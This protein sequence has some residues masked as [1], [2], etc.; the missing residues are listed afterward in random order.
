MC[1]IF[2]GAGI[3]RVKEEIHILVIEDV[4]TDVVMIN[5]ELRRGRM[6]FRSKRVETRDA[7]L[8]ELEQN[9]PDVIL[10]DHGLPSFDGFTALA[11]AKDKCPDVPF[12]F[13]TSALGESVTIQT[14]E[15]GA[16]DYVLKSQLSNLVPTIERALREA[17]ER[18]NHREAERALRESEE[19]FRMLVEGV[20]DY[21]IVMLDPQGRIT[22]WN[23][24]AEWMIGYRAEE[25][26]GQHFSRF[27]TAEDVQKHQPEQALRT[28]AAEGRHEEENWR[29]R[30]GG[31]KFRANVVLTA[32]RDERGQLR[33]FAN[34]TRN[35]TERIKV[36]DALRESEQ[37]FRLLVEGVVDYAI[38]T[39]DPEGRVTLWNNGGERLMGYSAEEIIGQPFARLYTREDREQHKPEEILREAATHGRFEE[40]GWRV[41]KD[42]SRFLA[43]TLTTAVH[44]D[45]GQLCGFS[46]IS[47]DVTAR[48]QTEQALRKSEQLYRTVAS[49]IPNGFVAIFDTDLRFLLVDGKEALESIGLSK[50]RLQGKTVG[51]IVPAG[52][53]ALVEPIYRGALDG[54]EVTTELPCEDRTF[55]V[56]ALP[57]RNGDGKI[58]A[59][60][61]LALDITERRLVEDR[62]RKL[63]EQLEQRVRE[64]TAELEAA[65][66]E[67]EAFSYSVSHDLRTPLRHID[68]FTQLLQKGAARKLDQQSRRHLET[69]AQATR[70]MN[71]LIDGLLA[72]SRTDRAELHKTALGL[73]DLVK[74]ARQ[75]LRQDAEGRTIQWVVGAL[76]EVRGDPALLRQVMVNLISNALKYTR[77]RAEARIEIGASETES[78]TVVFVRD[79]GVGFDAKYADRLF[80]VFQRLHSNEDFEGTGIG[81]ANVRRSIERHGGRTWAEGAV[82]AGATFYF[83][84]PKRAGG[85]T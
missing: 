66:K 46:R 40:E 25:I 44:D 15:S 51:E 82:D 78:E 55:L 72:L 47:R 21:A 19:R 57:L 13:V 84:L 16:T 29:T 77:P 63:N 81:L 59:G 64:R 34:V 1:K 26:L 58:Y 68:A 17:E 80:G 71:Q 4:P 69:I 31:S 45:A 18:V 2:G 65:N 37:R 56:N 73:N 5:H 74:A 11:I 30:K 39:L 22:S 3:E 67:L 70:Q 35:I 43:N 61:V 23:A 14:F 42:G 36:Q 53:Y 41:R 60:I 54:T 75:D 10:S 12:I 79:N 49:N 38:Y 8:R 27:Y 83:S 20:K 62:V 50:E 52:K 33:G 85:E 6:N 76:P 7:F 28:A 24:G 32:L 48:H 9:P